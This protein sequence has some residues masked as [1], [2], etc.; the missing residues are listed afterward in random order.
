MSPKKPKTLADKLFKVCWMSV[1]V[2]IGLGFVVS[3][4]GLDSEKADRDLKT[5]LGVL[6]ALIMLTVVVSGAA[7]VI[8]WMRERKKSN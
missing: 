8:V 4:L 1:V 2:F 5:I 3:A 6:A 7:S